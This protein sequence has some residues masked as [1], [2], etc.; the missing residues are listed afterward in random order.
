M[1]QDAEI[2]STKCWCEPPVGAEHGRHISALCWAAG[3]PEL[4]GEVVLAGQALPST[5]SS[6]GGRSW[7]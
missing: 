2:S 4:S 1:R 7:A 6:S 5:G 3:S